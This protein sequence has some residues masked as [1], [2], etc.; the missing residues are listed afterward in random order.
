LN[1]HWGCLFYTIWRY[2]RWN[3][4][5]F[6][7]LCR[8]W[9]LLRSITYSFLGLHNQFLLIP[10]L[11]VWALTQLF[12]LISKFLWNIIQ[13]IDLRWVWFW[14][15]WFLRLWFNCFYPCFCL[16]LLFLKQG[17][18]IGSMVWLRSRLKL[19]LNFIIKSFIYVVLLRGRRFNSYNRSNCFC[20]WLISFNCYLESLML[21]FI[22]SLLSLKVE[23]YFCF[24][25]TFLF[26]YF[27]YYTKWLYVWFTNRCAIYT[28]FCYSNKSIIIFLLCYLFNSRL[29]YRKLFSTNVIWR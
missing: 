1:W 25:L 20:W 10:L 21:L 19:I 29:N 5:L 24:L 15:S 26:F 3:K 7:S 6:N 27:F 9:G 16:L 28:W 11:T 2:W 8:I 17:S 12:W 4:I 18:L 22:N 14:N 13:I 23:L